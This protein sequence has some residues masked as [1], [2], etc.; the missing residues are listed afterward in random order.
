MNETKNLVQNWKKKIL[1]SEQCIYTGSSQKLWKKKLVCANKT[2]KF[3]FI[4]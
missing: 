2:Q 3:G 4:R 1:V